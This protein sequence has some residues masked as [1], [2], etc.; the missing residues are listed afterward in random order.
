MDARTSAGIAGAK[1]RVESERGCV[2]M[3]REKGGKGRKWVGR[4][5]GGHE[6]A[7]MGGRVRKVWKFCIY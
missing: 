6:R 5:K 4:R 2:D 7:W 3:G 1:E